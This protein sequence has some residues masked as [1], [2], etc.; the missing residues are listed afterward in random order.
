MPLRRFT[1]LIAVALSWAATSA[2]AHEVR[3]GYLQVQ[4]SQFVLVKPLPQRW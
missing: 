3:P 1:F 4:D 2:H